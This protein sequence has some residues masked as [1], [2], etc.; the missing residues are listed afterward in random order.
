M[1]P[2]E[3]LNDMFSTAEKRFHERGIETLPADINHIQPMLDM[4]LEHSENSKG[5]YTVFLTSLVFKTLHPN[6]DIRYHQA[7]MTGG[8]GYSGRSFDTSYITPFL[9]HHKFPAM[10]ESGWLTRS[11]EQKVPYDKQYT[12][13]IRPKKL[14]VAFLEA[15]DFIQ[16]CEQ[17]QRELI[18]LYFLE[19]LIRNRETTKIEVA[20]PRNLSISQII[21]LLQKHFSHNYMTSGTA[22]LPVIAIYSIYQMLMNEL[23]RFSSGYKLLDLEAHTSAD[24]QSGRMGDIDIVGQN[25][26][27]FEAVEVK[28]DI[29]ISPSMVQIAYDKFISTSMKRYYILST[30]GVEDEGEIN[31][32]ILEIKNIHGCQV[33]VNG[34]YDTL[35]YYL[36]LLNDPSAFLEAY[37]TNLKNDPTIKFGHKEYWN[38]L[39]SSGNLF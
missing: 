34:I 15:I 9:K 32:L 17:D 26:E 37:A 20:T 14:K 11:L 23:Q 1:N 7:N 35:K 2:S 25:E 36:R 13:A 6:Q 18:L 28:F 30:A 12:G 38:K 5:C 3:F 29:P 19:G 16:F 22:R 8:V 21:L 39:I 31:K 24:S 4:L 10:Q 27:P 33:I